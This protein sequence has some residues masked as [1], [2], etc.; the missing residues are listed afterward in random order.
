MPEIIYILTNEAMPGY[1]K[2]GKT[3]NLEQRIRQLDTTGTPLPFECFYACTVDDSLKVERLIHDAFGDHRVRKNREFF[4]LSPAR[5]L[6]ALKLV[7]KENVTPNKD[8]VETPEDQEALN[9]ARKKRARFSFDMAKIPIGS[10]ITFFNDDTIKAKVLDNKTIELNGE[11]TSLSAS[12]QKIL[13]YSY[14][15][16]GPCFWLYEGE[17]LY[18]RRKRLESEE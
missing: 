11:Q 15:I 8:Y 13:G 12:A 6:S 17:L 3:D 5:A 14:A 9:Q 16:A 10:E 18:E 7:E 2:I 4:E 1:I